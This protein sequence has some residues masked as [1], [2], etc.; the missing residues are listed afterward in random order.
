MPRFPPAQP[1]ADRSPSVAID[2]RSTLTKQAAQA[3][4]TGLGA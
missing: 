3:P 1:S 2:L 4:L